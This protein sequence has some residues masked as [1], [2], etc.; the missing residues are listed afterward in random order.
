[1]LQFFNKK[2][3]IMLAIFSLFIFIS[4]ASVA[5]YQKPNFKIRNDGIV[6]NFSINSKN[7]TYIGRLYTRDVQYLG[8]VDSD[9]IDKYVQNLK[10]PDNAIAIN[11]KFYN[12]NNDL[13]YEA[14]KVLIN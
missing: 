10:A 5:Y 8:K 7:Q 14:S 13:K 3:L 9:I 11:I 6:D 1:M 2:R 12:H 4:I